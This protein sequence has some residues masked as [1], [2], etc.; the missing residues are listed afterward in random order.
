MGFTGLIL[1]VRRTMTSLESQEDNLSLAF[2]NLWSLPTFL[3]PWPPPAT[4]P[5]RPLL[6]H[7]I[8]SDSDILPLSL[9]RT[10]LTTLRPLGCPE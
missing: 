3:G 8:S 7:H 2:S 1:D 5:L 9:L 6:H 4:T 10:L